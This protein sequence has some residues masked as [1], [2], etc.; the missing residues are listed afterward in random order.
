M[1]I[2]RRKKLLMLL[3]LLAL[4]ILVTVI[5]AYKSY[6]V[7][8]SIS[9]YYLSHSMHQISERANLVVQKV[10]DLKE[11]YSINDLNAILE[12][13]GMIVSHQDLI[14]RSAFEGDPTMMNPAL[15]SALY[16]SLLSTLNQARESV[17]VNLDEDVLAELDDLKAYCQG[18]SGVYNRSTADAEYAHDIRTRHAVKFMREL[19]VQY[20]Q[21]PS[22]KSL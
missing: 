16:D 7:Q 21:I 14:Y 2:F 22:R 11:P 5:Y 17:T 8:R 13:V 1:S 6:S 10:N 15:L 4:V 20:D 19:K 18:I 9:A 3:M 12:H